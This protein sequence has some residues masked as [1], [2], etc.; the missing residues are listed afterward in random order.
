MDR[1]L[2]K[3][4]EVA[5]MLSVS[6][7]TTYVMAARGEIPTVRIRGGLRVPVDALKAWIDKHLAHETDAEIRT[8]T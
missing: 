2:L 7:S 6:R 1:L 3:M 5:Q 4:S 8:M